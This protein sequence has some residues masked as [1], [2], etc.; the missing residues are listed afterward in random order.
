M[1]FVLLF[2]LVISL[3]LI[4][5]I[6]SGAVLAQELVIVHTNDF[7]GHIQET[8]KYAGAARIAAEVKAIREN[9][10][11]VIFLDAGD[12]ISGTPVSSMFE[13]EPIFEVMNT[14]G[15]DVGL[16]GNHEFDHGYRKIER[17]RDLVDHPL[18][19]A[20][21]YGPDGELLGDAPYVILDVAG[22][23]VGVIGLVTQ[24]APIHFSPVGNE[25]LTFASPAE[26]LTTLI[27]SIRP[28]VDVL[29]VLAHIGHEEELA[30]AEQFQAIDVIIG[31][32]S[33]TLVEQPVQ[34]G[35][36][37]VAQAHH[38][39]TH[40]GLVRVNRA[41]GKPSGPLQIRGKLLKAKDLA[42]PDAMVE[43]LVSL[44]ESKVEDEVDVQISKTTRAYS[45]A[46]LQPILESILAQAAGTELGFYNRRGIR[47][48]LSV[49]PVT[50]RML[51][52]IEPFGNT[53][54]RMRIKGKDLIVLLSQEPE[55]HH[56]VPNIDP[57][58]HY[59]LATNSY[60]ASH[61]DLAFGDDIETVD[62]GLLIRDILIQHIKANGLE[63]SAGH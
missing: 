21:A 6:N 1:H 7:H 33:H 60:I 8:Q 16:L 12:A 5:L 41:P 27:P 56:S 46:E 22:I 53:L 44:F 10:E 4:S 55:L 3:V 2:K 24:D 9:N 20:N 57:D 25:G 36:T 29:V 11:A 23:S 18:L 48:E 32:H 52:N 31:G 17:F 14:M 13:G 15:Y 42:K 30:L 40:L 35:R 39:G 34:V 62:T 49:G 28:R 47:D 19:S 43:N 45:K 54:V 26:R 61:A 51:W 37:A 63:S 58:R 38:Y 50:A 59:H